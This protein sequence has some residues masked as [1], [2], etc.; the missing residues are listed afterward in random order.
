MKLKTKS[1]AAEALRLL[2]AIPNDH[3]TLEMTL[4]MGNLYRQ[5]GSTRIAIQCYKTILKKQPLALEALFAMLELGASWSEVAHI[6]TETPRGFEWVKSMAMATHLAARHKYTDAMKKYTTLDKQCTNNVLV[7]ARLAH[8]F[9]HMEDFD[10]ALRVFEK[11]HQMDPTFRYHMDVYA[12]VIHHKGD[13]SMLNRLVQTMIRYHPQQPET[14]TS[15]G[16]YLDLKGRKAKAMEHLMKAL[17]LDPRH[18]MALLQRGVILHS[19]SRMEESLYIFKKA[20]EVR[21]SCTALQGMAQ[22]YI[23]LQKPAE[24]TRIAQQAFRLMPN[25]PKAVTLY[26]LVLLHQ[27]EH[28]TEAGK[29]IDRVLKMDPTYVDAIIAKSHLFLLEEQYD[30][31][32]QILLN[33][34]EHT[35]NAQVYTKLG[36]LCEMQK[37]SAEALEYYEKALRICPHHTLAKERLAKL[38]QDD[39]MP[40]GGFEEEDSF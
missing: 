13:T 37:K 32:M 20:A 3:R 21:K 8:C 25:H 2:Q 34:V 6:Y 38:Q 30:K 23:A 35:S 7:K 16:I 18:E 24:A 27:R 9:V 10:N 4:C 28:R 33:C 39:A 22:S 11:V 12:S 26:G 19:M 29:I 14:W 15:V 1:D 31:A 36:E 40:G 17:A 5:N